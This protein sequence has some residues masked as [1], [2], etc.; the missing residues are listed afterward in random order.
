MSRCSFI[1]A[2]G[3]R[4]ERTVSDGY[5]YCYSHNPSRAEERSRNAK[6][7]GKTGG[8]GRAK[9]VEQELIDLKHQLQKI[10]DGV[11]GGAVL[12]GQAT[13]AVQALNCLARI[14]ELQR[15]WR[16]LGEVEE[17]L[18][19]LEQRLERRRGP[20]ESPE[21]VSGGPRS[22]PGGEGRRAGASGWQPLPHRA[23]VGAGRGSRLGRGDRGTR[24]AMRAL[25]EPG[26]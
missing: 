6:K 9:P 23:G 20:P 13:A 15:R 1:R 4:C 16:E 5:E 7:A 11:L 12:Q 14:L 18:D 26:A 8:K 21:A 19:A 3:A 17:R 22:T 25:P 10:A 2:D 24:P